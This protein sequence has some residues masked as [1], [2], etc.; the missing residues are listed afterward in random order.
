MKTESVQKKGRVLQAMIRLLVIGAVVFLLS[1]PCKAANTVTAARAASN[2]GKVSVGKTYTVTVKEVFG[3][4]V[5]TVPKTGMYYF[6]V[7]GLRKN[8]VSLKKD[9]SDMD[10]YLQNASDIKK[11][12]DTDYDQIYYQK[13]SKVY[14]NASFIKSKNYI[15][16]GTKKFC[17]S[18]NNNLSKKYRG[19][20][21]NTG[22]IR[23]KQGSSYVL[24]SDFAGITSANSKVGRGW[25]YKL[26][27]SYVN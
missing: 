4:L 11:T 2:A 14:G 15:H 6:E 13:F 18:L 24:V 10:F 22:C 1:D 25:K 16:L 21:R 7:S 12:K 23:L 20:T 5:F 17:Q 27:I 8:G 19:Y 26:R 9:G 3:G